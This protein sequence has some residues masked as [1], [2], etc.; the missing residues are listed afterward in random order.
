MQI[1][2]TG[3]LQHLGRLGVKQNEL[4]DVRKLVF[5]ADNI[6]FLSLAFLSLYSLFKASITFAVMSKF[7]SA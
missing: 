6:Y 5:A 3:A 1:N 2:G 4:S 7:L